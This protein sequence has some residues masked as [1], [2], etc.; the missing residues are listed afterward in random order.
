MEKAGLCV[1]YDCNNFG[2]M[3]QIFATQ[4]AINQAGWDYEI[5]RYDKQTLKFYLENTTRIFNPYFMKGKISAFEKNRKLKAWPEVQKGNGIRNQYIAEYRK[6]QAVCIFSVDLDHFKAVNDTYG[7]K[8]GDEALKATS[9]V[10]KCS[11]PTGVVCRFGGDEFL[12]L[13]LGS[14]SNDAARNMA[15][16]FLV[17]L[18][19]RF[20]AQEEFR[21][22]SGSVG[23]AI[24]HN[25]RYPIDELIKESDAA[26]YEAKSAGRDCVR[27][28]WE[29][30][31]AK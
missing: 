23:I 5:I 1:R 6:N 28:A 20:Q 9:E 29:L 17:K 3:L 10:L 24:S 26:L 31:E 27:T 8:A 14:L 18:R 11:F 19:E 13:L 21:N 25:I 22:L 2:S 16:V 15:E 30:E 7:H 12:V 4:K